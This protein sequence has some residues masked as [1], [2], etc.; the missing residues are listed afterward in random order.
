MKQ[1]K[2]LLQD[3]QACRRHHSCRRVTHNSKP[4]DG[5]GSQ[6]EVTDRVTRQ[7]EYQKHAN[8]GIQT[9]GAS[10]RR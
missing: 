2:T 6:Y 7:A 10:R 1:A 9:D 8:N 5:Q 3:R 4:R